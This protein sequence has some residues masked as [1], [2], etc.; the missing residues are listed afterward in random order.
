MTNT[1]SS[2]SGALAGI[3]ELHGARCRGQWD[4]WDETDNPEII[5]YTKRQCLSCPA[6]AECAEWF[7]SLKPSKRPI[8]TVAGKLVH[9][10][11]KGVA[12]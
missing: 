11:N 9:Q 8:G 3:P 4:L 5:E 1:W 12:A 2:L 7:N 10:H 6:L